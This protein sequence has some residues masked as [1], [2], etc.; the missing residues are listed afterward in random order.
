MKSYEV[1]FDGIVGPTH[2]YS[3]L[4]YG[5]IASLTNKSAV[6]KPKLAALQGLKKMKFLMD[7]G[8][9]QA[10]IPP[11]QRPNLN[12]LR[13]AGFYGSDKSVIDEALKNAPWLFYSCCSASSM[14]T[15]NAATVSPSSDNSDRLVHITPANLFNKF[16]RS[17][18]AENTAKILK[19]IFYDQRYF[20]HHPILAPGSALSDEGA[21][22]HTR[23]CKQFHETGIQL[24][25]YGRKAFGDETSKT[26]VKYPGRQTFEAS[27]TIARL[28]RL[29]LE[30]VV[31]AQQNPEAVDAGVFHNDVISVGH[32]NIFFYHEQAFVDTDAIVDQISCKM[33]KICNVEMSLIKVSSMQVSLEDAV[34]SYLFN[35]QIV[36]RYDGKRILI[37]PAECEEVP[38][39]KAFLAKLMQ[40]RERIFHEIHY[41]NLRESMQNGGGPAC[42]RLRVVLNE[43]E[44]ASIKQTVLLT[45][46]LYE[47]LVDWVNC[48]YRDE[49]SVE[50][51]GDPRLGE[52]SG[53]ALHELYGLLDLKFAG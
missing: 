27:Q 21:A 6:S 46:R 29:N 43:D 25:V 40:D 44:L 9:K 4:S 47:E 22:N 24:F 7:L 41:L 38:A 30:C 51:L 19:E 3:G 20:I 39:V 15:A 16:H 36:N 53:V 50:D 45:D 1:N 35:S 14:W 11:Q 42:L 48:H 34:R 49:L 8:I 52:E 23:F 32:E 18:E 26:S 12:I 31:M 10:V 33:A 2:N 5:N 28:H 37:A 17:I 13:H